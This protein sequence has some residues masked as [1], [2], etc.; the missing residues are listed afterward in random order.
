VTNFKIAR[1]KLLDPSGLTIDQLEQVLGRMSSN[2]VDYAD[3]YFQYIEA[4]SWFL[5]DNIVKS[6]S[7]SIDQGVGVRAL[8]GEKTGFSYSD[9]I[10]LDSLIKSAD[11]AKT[12]EEKGGAFVCQ[13][14]VFVPDRQIYQP[15]NPLSTL[16]ETQ[17][18]DLLRK[19]DKVA[20]QEDN[21]VKQVMVSLTGCYELVLVM[22]ND[23][24]LAA[25]VRP[26]IRLSVTVIVEDNG[27]IEQGSYGGGGRRSYQTLVEND[28]ATVYAKEAVREALV[29]LEATE[30]P[31]GIMP[32]ILGSGWPA[33][34]LHEAVGHGL[35]G[36]FCRK[37]TSAFSGRLG[38]KVASS[39]CTIVD[40]GILPH[41]RGSLNI[42]DE[43]VPSQHTVLI[44]DGVLKGYML[45][46]LNARLL[47]MQSTGNARREIYSQLPMPRMTNTYM[48]PGTHETEEMIASVKKGLYAVNFSGG[49]VDITSGKFVFTTS[50]AYLIEN[51]KVTRPIKDATLIGNGPDV[52]TKVSMVGNELQLD[53]GVGNCGKEGQ[54]VPVG[55]G[56]PV[57]KVDEMTVGGSAVSA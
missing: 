29:N 40:D 13:P 6:S 28:C 54:C 23:G 15:L 5:E 55:V 7:F 34:L 50:E 30:A 37:G 17:K 14:T 27:H 18:V 24:T 46:K 16:T 21:R 52:L 35:E 8:S 12:I 33:V 9:N 3:L 41:L 56:Q 1:Q 48:L 49:Q 19:V 53:G 4:E 57:L 20:R 39:L 26:L 32:V 36:D 44:E 47:K 25:D 45:D 31:A 51:G 22:A 2:A 38:Q 43:G 11:I 42:D 10:T